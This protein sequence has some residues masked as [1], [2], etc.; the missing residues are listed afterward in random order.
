MSS[1]VS[2]LSSVY[3]VEFLSSWY[4]KWWNIVI[5]WNHWSNYFIRLL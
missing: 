3:S 4:L 1:I 2:L 5:Y